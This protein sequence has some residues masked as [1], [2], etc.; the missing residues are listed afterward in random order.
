M[1]NLIK[2]LCKNHQITLICE[3]RNNQTN[4]DVEELKKFCQ[5]VIVVNRKKQWSLG[6]IIK[7]GFSSNAFLLTGHANPEMKEKII[8]EMAKTK[9]DLIHVETFY[10][11]Q[12]LPQT[13]IPV[14]LAEHN[15]EYLVYKRF[16]KRANFILK[17]LLYFDVYK[18]K[19]QEKKSWDKAKVIIAVSEKE[20]RLM[21]RQNVIVVANGVDTN[22][23]T[24]VRE[25]SNK[26]EKRVL[27]IGDFRWI[28][29][30]DAAGWIM[31][32]IWPMLKHLVLS[33]NNREKELKKHNFL[34]LWVVGRKIPDFLKRLITNG[35]VIL[36]QNAP[37]ETSE[38]FK[39]A[40]VLLA[41]IRVGGGTSFKILEAMASGVAV[42][43]T[44]LGVEGLN[45]EDGKH[46]LIAKDSEEFA[47]KT[48]QILQGFG[49]RKT[50]TENARA[51]IEQT[52]DWRIIVKDLE[53]AYTLAVQ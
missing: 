42:V 10:V 3:K 52:Y 41:P 2:L 44:K 16:A 7:T 53:K 4:L 36:D 14:V 22:R 8:K 38:I 28:Q 37:S 40:E 50:L 33:S 13:G 1:Y 9:F 12:N 17:P 5:K 29:N 45:V 15:I 6:N 26:L 48:L 11:M 49:I 31:Q 24:F 39:Q 34:K 25:N 18:L 20:K 35:D 19:A 47:Q 46:I 30:R 32:E 21:K 23:F 51:F 27:F 43:T